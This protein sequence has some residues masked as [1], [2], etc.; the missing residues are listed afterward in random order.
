[1]ETGVEPEFTEYTGTD[2]AQHVVSLNVNRRHLT[3]SQRAWA[4][5]KLAN[6]K[7]GGDRVSEQSLNLNSG[8]VTVKQAADMLNVSRS[9][10]C[11]AK[12]VVDKASP[13][14]KH[15]VESGELAVSTAANVADLPIQ[16]QEEA[17]SG[18]IKA[19][20]KAASKVRSKNLA[21][22]DAEDSE[23]EDAALE[24]AAK[25]VNDRIGLNAYN[26]RPN[27]QFVI[28]SNLLTQFRFMKD[29]KDLSQMSDTEWAHAIKK[30]IV[31]DGSEEI[32]RSYYRDDLLALEE[33]LERFS[34]ALNLFKSTGKITLINGDQ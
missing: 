27:D 12:K 1:M 2:P 8:A 4:A 31:K 16:E 10:V 19:I 21:A 6:I 3:E 13:E 26:G 22:L 30:T 25:R 11:F 20:K 9:S 18:G 28:V 14:L 15:L 34:A 29:Q 24:A 5:A 32:H 17:A 7:N 33:G 23:E